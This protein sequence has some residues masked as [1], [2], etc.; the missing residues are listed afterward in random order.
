MGRE[1]LCLTQLPLLSARPFHISCHELE[2]FKFKRR[3]AVKISPAIR[4]RTV[5]LVP[6]R[7][8]P[9][10]MVEMGL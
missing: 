10:R 2:A 4:I 3:D 8:D 6:E 9:V 5:R 7:I 1:R